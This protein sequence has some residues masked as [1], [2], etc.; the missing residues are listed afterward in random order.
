MVEDAEDGL[1]AGWI[2]SRFVPDL[3]LLDLHLPKVDGYDVCE[4]L[5]SEPAFKKT[6]IIAMS[7]HTPEK[8]ARILKLG[9]DSFLSK[10]FELSDLE[11][12]MRRQ[13]FAGQTSSV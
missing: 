3:V 2:L 8:E 9:A 5:K 13:L 12:S 6:K 11:R 4:F 1:Q 10:P 7:T